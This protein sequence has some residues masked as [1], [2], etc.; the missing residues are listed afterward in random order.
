[1]VVGKSNKD[2][3]ILYYVHHGTETRNDR[4]LEPR[5]ERDA[6]GKIMSQRQRDIYYKK[7]DCLWLYYY[8]FKAIS[9]GIDT[10]E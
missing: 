7:K 4:G 3:L 10:R 5:V 1:M 9:K 6:E 8:S 2:R